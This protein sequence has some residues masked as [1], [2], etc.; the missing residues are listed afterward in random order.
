MDKGRALSFAEY[1]TGGY[2][3]HDS[4]LTPG[5]LRSLGLK[6]ALNVPDDVHAFMKLHKLTSNPS[7]LSRLEHKVRQDESTNPSSVSHIRGTG[8]LG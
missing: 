3:T 8:E 7:G 2:L 6:I 4:P 5:E 1:M